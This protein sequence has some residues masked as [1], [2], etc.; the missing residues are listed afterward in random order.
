M[1]RTDLAM[2]AA[3]NV[4]N[5]PGV[6]VMERDVI[7]GVHRV[8]VT[9]TSDEGERAVGKKK[10]SYV[11]LEAAELAMGNTEI[12]EACS[13]QLAEEIKH[14]AGSAADA[15]VLVVGLGNHMVTPDAL[16]PAVCDKVFVSRHIHEYA[17]NAIDARIGN[18][19]A[20][21]PGVLGI[22]GVETGEIIEGVVKR[23][24]P[25]LIIAIDSLASMSIDRI[26]TT[27]QVA[28]TGISPGAGI[29]NK[30][31]A[32]DRETLGVPVLAIGVPLV[33]YASTIAQQLVDEAMNKGPVDIV[34]Q[35]KMQRAL[36]GIKDVE[37]ADM[38]VTP[39]EIDKVVEDLSRI[40]ADG[41]NIA[42][43][44]HITLEEAHRYMH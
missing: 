16:G 8:R 2:E 28:D 36:G 13:K 29:G 7:P 12:D 24:R 33:V 27:I 6:D 32:I 41:L 34:L 23:I 30:R 4:G 38:I 19:S 5:I 39:K 18:V 17:P 21:S 25:A 42:L 9:I 43:H 1:I 35:E 22:T 40:L 3:Q 15:L 20:I 11:T 14:M 37:G 10:G 26:R 31:K 44:Q